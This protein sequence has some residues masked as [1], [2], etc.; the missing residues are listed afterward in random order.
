MKGDDTMAKRYSFIC[1]KCGE[2][3]KV[4]CSKTYVRYCYCNKC[5]IVY[6]IQ[7]S[8]DKIITTIHRL[9]ED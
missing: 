9:E 8:T 4:K 6:A 3:T 7:R 5:N 2:K 1:P